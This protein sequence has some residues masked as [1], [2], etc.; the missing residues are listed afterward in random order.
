MNDFFTEK[1]K[2]AIDFFNNNLDKWIADPMLKMKYVVIYEDKLQGFYDNFENALSKAVSMFQPGEFIV[3][4]V[5]SEE[6]VSG[7]LY[8]AFAP[9]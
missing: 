9:V 8:S 6:E 1:Q 4:Q 3:Q 5:I 7:F 2:Q